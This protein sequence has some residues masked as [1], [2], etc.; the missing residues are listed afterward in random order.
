MIRDGKQRIRIGG[1]VDADDLGLLVDDV[2]DEARILMAE[3]VVILPP[4][5]ARQEIIERRDRP[6]PRDVMADLEPFGVLVEHRIDDVDEGL[7]TRKEAMPA[8][9]QI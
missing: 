2:I 5:V 3:P 9:E 6:T 7:I 8:R 1:Q 4:N